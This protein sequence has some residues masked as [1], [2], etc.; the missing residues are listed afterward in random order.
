[1]SPDYAP[2]NLIDLACQYA[3]EEYEFFKAHN[4]GITEPL[5]P[6][7]FHGTQ[8]L[9]LR[10]DLNKGARKA[11][12]LIPDPMKRPIGFS[13]LMACLYDIFHGKNSA[14]CKQV[15]NATLR[16]YGIIPP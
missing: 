16:Q 14:L 12:K 5:T 4:F 8:Y 15:Y 2:S 6:N 11:S 10:E 1:M 7:A 9:R 3:K 13:V